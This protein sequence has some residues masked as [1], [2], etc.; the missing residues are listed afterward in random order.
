M[1]GAE[2]VPVASFAQY[3]ALICTYLAIELIDIA[4]VIL[5]FCDK[6]L[7]LYNEKSKLLP[8]HHN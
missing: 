5:P 4:N 7:S 8:V 3:L 6:R 2:H 1:F